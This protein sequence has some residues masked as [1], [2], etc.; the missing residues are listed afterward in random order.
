MSKRTTTTKEYD[1]EGRLVKETV[2]EE[3]LY[4]AAQPNQGWW[5]QGLYGGGFVE[6]PRQVPP[7]INCFERDLS[8]L[9]V[10]R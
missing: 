8:P 5:Q 2:V 4:D 10:Q 9:G 6:T 7:I 1:A 3:T